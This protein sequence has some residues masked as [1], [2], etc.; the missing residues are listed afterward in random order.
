MCA[1]PHFYFISSLIIICYTANH[2][3]HVILHLFF[4]VALDFKGFPSPLGTDLPVCDSW[5]LEQTIW[6]HCTLPKWP[7]GFWPGVR[8]P[9]SPSVTIQR[10]HWSPACVL[11]LN[12]NFWK[13][14]ISRIRNLNADTTVWSFLAFPGSQCEGCSVQTDGTDQESKFNVSPSGMRCIMTLV[15]NP[16]PVWAWVSPWVSLDFVGQWWGKE[17]RGDRRREGWSQ[18]NLFGEDQ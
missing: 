1:L 13:E 12:C 8:R 9:K 3:E 14:L 4:V 15:K 17:C 5:I 11:R 16:D 10:I 7:G 18:G 6:Y 2:Y